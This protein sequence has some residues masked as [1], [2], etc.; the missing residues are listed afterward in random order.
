[1]A[2]PKELARHNSVVSPRI[3]PDLR[4]GH[5]GSFVV[6]EHLVRTHR[7]LKHSEEPSIRHVPP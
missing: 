7:P 5:L 6:A 3:E 2:F 1:M 4:V